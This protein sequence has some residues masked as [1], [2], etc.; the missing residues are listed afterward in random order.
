MLQE[1]N[2]NYARYGTTDSKVNTFVPGLETMYWV[3][4]PCMLYCCDPIFCPISVIKLII[5]TKQYASIHTAK[6]G[7]SLQTGTKSKF[8][9]T[10]KTP[11]YHKSM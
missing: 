3:L 10:M 9:C 1:A 6:R 2:K 4:D 5:I 11:H 8:E 7:Q